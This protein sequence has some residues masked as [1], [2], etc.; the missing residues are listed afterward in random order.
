ME[1]GKPNGT[2]RPTKSAVRKGLDRIARDMQRWQDDSFNRHLFLEKPRAQLER[3]VGSPR[4]G[5]EEAIGPL[6]RLGQWYLNLGVVR[7]W[8]GETGA[9]ALSQSS[10]CS[11]WGYR[12]AAGGFQ[13]Q[14]H[15]NRES[16]LD[17]NACCL[18]MALAVVVDRTDVVKAMGDLVLSGLQEGLFHD[19]MAS[20]LAPFLLRVVG[21]WGEA[22][23]REFGSRVRRAASLDR[24]ADCCWSESS[25]DVREA[26]LKACD[27]HLERSRESTRTEHFEFA[28]QPYRILP[29]EILSVLRSREGRGLPTP[30]V[31]HALLEIP[32]GGLFPLVRPLADALLEETVRKCNR[33]I[34]GSEA[35]SL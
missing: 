12:A 34:G 17:L 9:D 11:S 2:G 33:E 28:H 27:Y 19:S 8:A 20:S 6:Q 22:A 32:T 21:K 10:F 1:V 24:L 7:I 3:F 25:E 18:V 23:E 13:A 4:L 29:V 5:M 35:A 15:S 30:G 26:L 14:K 16:R 31:Q